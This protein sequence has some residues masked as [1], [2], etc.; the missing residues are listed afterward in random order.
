MIFSNK[1]IN[2]SALNININNT[3]ITRV[4]ECKFLG[5]TIDCKLSLKSH[6][7]KVK[8]KLVRCYAILYKASLLLN[9]TTMHTLYCSLFLPYLNY[10]C[11]V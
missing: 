2:D 5:V 10:C 1:S 6:I 4:Y 11:E 7:A 8:D 9:V 3:R